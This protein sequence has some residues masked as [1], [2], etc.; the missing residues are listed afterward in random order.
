M[1][2][3]DQT[4]SV[5]SLARALRG[6]LDERK[7]T[8]QIGTKTLALVLDTLISVAQPSENN[9]MTEVAGRTLHGMM[10]AFSPETKNGA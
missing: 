6:G 7:E 10:T 8:T 3:H 1:R 2:V 4:A 9:R 5:V